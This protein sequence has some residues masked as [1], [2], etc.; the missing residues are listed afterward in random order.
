MSL[1]Q[2]HSIFPAVFTSTPAGKVQ[3]A[4]DRFLQVK[5]AVHKL[6]VSVFGSNKTVA[7]VFTPC[8]TV[9]VIE[10]TA[11]VPAIIAA[12]EICS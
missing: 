3:F 4:V 12:P 7:K 11:I 9:A 5:K 1:A 2:M 8:I 10:R 6:V